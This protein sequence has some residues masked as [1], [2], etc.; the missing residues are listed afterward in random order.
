M[1]LHSLAPRLV[2]GLALAAV[3]AAATRVLS[4]SGNAPFARIDTSWEKRPL[5]STTIRVK[6]IRWTKDTEQHDGGTESCGPTG[7]KDDDGTNLR[8]NRADLPETSHLTTVDAIRSLPDTALW[9]FRNR[10]K[11]THADS[12]L[13]FPYEGIALTVEGYFEIVKPQKSSPSS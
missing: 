4:D 13:V 3:A 1:G 5:K 10:E 2:L 8:K 9:R 7:N 12:A 11:W 6:A